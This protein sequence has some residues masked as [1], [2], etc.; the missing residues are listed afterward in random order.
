M[1]MVVMAAPTGSAPE[2]GESYYLYNVGQQTY[3]GTDGNGQLTLTG[4]RILVTLTEDENNKEQL[5]F[6]KLTCTEGNLSCSTFEAPRCDSKGRFDQWKFTAVSGKTNVYYLSARNREFNTNLYLYYSVFLQSIATEPFKPWTELTN[7]Q[8]M[9]VKSTDLENKTWEFKETET[10]C[11]V[12]TDGAYYDVTL[13]RKLSKEN[14]NSFCVPFPISEAELKSQFGDEVQVAEFTS[15]DEYHI[16][17]TTATAVEAGKPCIIRPTSVTTDNTYKFS[18]VNK[19]AATVENVGQTYDGTTVTYQGS[20]VPKEV[21]IA[22]YVFGGDNKVYHLTKAQ[23]MQG[24]RAY[25]TEEAVN[26]GKYMD[27]TLD[28]TT[29]GITTATEETTAD[30]PV[31]NLQG[32]RVDS[33]QLPHGIY[34]IGGR[35]VIK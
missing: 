11:S 2:K 17:F 29:T 7:A 1:A 10:T 3:L 25:F 27:W 26:E 34:I 5:G 35:K 21:P 18:N 20:Y 30:G 31:Y 13:V 14:W 12:P 28:G 22:A 23:N 16:N 24:F 9:L 32:Q 19:F 6:Y 4:T 8:W 15:I 33:Y